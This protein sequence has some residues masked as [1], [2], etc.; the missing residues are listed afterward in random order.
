MLRVY[1]FFFVILTFLVL[2]C[3]KK[4]DPLPPISKKPLFIDSFNLKQ[5]GNSLVV[6][7]KYTP[8]YDD[9]R[10]LKDFKFKVYLNGKVVYVDISNLSDIYWFYFTISSLKKEYCFNI[11]V[12]SKDNESESSPIKCIIP[13][14]SFPSKP[15]I[16]GID[17]KENGLVLRWSGNGEYINIY[18]SNRELIPPVTLKK[19]K[20]NHKYLDNDLVFNKE[21]C[22]YITTENNGVESERSET[23]CK[24]FEDVFPPKPPSDFKLLKRNNDYYLIWKESPSND[25]IGYILYKNGKPI[26]DIPIKTYF[27]VDKDYKKGDEYSIVA[28]DRA[29]NRSVMVYLKEII[30]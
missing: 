25:V 8:R 29:G 1:R 16:L 4:G 19:V 13:S 9:N 22:Y 17:I 15:K 14:T 18:R 10:P 24:K 11:Y 30:E 3:G 5:M 6:F 21:Y 26:F 23:V 12:V 20:N 28:V 2:G 27:F 7:W